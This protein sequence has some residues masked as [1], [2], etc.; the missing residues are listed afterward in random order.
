M[1]LTP[2]NYP[3]L[4]A[5]AERYHAAVKEAK[6]ANLE[7]AALR[8]AIKRACA[9][10]MLVFGAVAR[11]YSDGEKEAAASDASRAAPDRQVLMTTSKRGV[12][13]AQD[14]LRRMRCRLSPRA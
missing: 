6:V 10:Y 5:A 8:V 9:A 4:K 11:Q 2:A 3:E 14:T 1:L 12:H 7:G 13:R